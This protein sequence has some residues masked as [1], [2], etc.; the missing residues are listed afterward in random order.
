MALSVDVLL[1]N[2]AFREKTSSRQSERRGN[3]HRNWCVGLFLLRIKLVIE[4]EGHVM[5]QERG[6]ALGARCCRYV[7]VVAGVAVEEVVGVKRLVA[8]H[9]VF[10]DANYGRTTN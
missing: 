7:A 1:S 4:R 10:F 3:N 5:V 8:R 6:T 2:D 9:R